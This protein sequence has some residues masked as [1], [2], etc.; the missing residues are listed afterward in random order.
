MKKLFFY[1]LALPLMALAFTS[2]DDD[3]KD[4]PNVTLSIQYS[5]ATEEDGTL[6]VEQ[7]QTLK[8][9]ALEAVP[10]E[11]TKKATLGQTIYYWDG[12]PVYSTIVV[13]FATEINTTGM[14]LGEHSLGVRSTVYQVDKEVGFALATF[15]VMVVAPEENPDEP[16]SGTITPEVRISD[17][18]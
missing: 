13:P 15:K 17:G 9:D 11:G 2:C 6:F 7:G 16:G 10:A 12:L 18:E 14:E 5:G 8:I 3:D 1:L 4:L